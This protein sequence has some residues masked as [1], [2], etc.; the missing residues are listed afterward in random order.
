MVLQKIKCLC[1]AGHPNTSLAS[2]ST[3]HH[4]L[5]AHSQRGSYKTKNSLVKGDGP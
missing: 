4:C 1:I 5:K 2:V 3:Q